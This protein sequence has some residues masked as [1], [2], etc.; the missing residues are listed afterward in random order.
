MDKK[1][2][3]K[4]EAIT[5]SSRDM[6]PLRSILLAR[7]EVKLLNADIDYDTGTIILLLTK[8]KPSIL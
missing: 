5:I 4:A 1:D 2:N 8:M 7:S 3:Q 6:I